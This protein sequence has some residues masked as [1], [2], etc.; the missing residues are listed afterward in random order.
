M[1]T[2][3]KGTES[4][5]AHAGARKC[6]FRAPLADC[7][8]KMIFSHLLHIKL[9]ECKHKITRHDM[10]C[11]LQG[12]KQGMEFHGELS[13]IENRLTELINVAPG[14]TSAWVMGGLY[15]NA[16]ASAPASPARARH[17]PTWAASA[18]VLSYNKR[19]ERPRITDRMIRVKSSLAHQGM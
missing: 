5:Y 2:S 8:K 12:E 6:V 9:L 1:R 16:S 19:R 15:C 13:T 7:E 18:R 3:S 17:L 14:G 10:G 4:T 11:F